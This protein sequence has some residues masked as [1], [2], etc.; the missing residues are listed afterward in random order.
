[1]DPDAT[2]RLAEKAIADEDWA[3]AGDLLNA[4]F[5]WTRKGGYHSDGQMLRVHALQ[6]VVVQHE[7][8]Q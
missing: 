4:Y 8:Y 7:K 3:L 2:V 5:E 1:M 6:H